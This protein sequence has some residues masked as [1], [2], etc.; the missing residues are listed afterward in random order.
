MTTVPAVPAKASAQ[1][2]ADLIEDNYSVPRELLDRLAEKIAWD[3]IQVGHN[4]ALSALDDWR[5]EW[6]TW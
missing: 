5:G 3:A 4:A 6:L 2:I 1:T